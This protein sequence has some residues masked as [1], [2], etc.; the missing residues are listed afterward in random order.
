MGLPGQPHT[1]GKRTQHQRGRFGRSGRGGGEMRL[2]PLQYI[3]VA[4]RK[5]GDLPV[6]LPPFALWGLLCL[7]HTDQQWQG[8]KQHS[9]FVHAPVSFPANTR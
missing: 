6:G 4:A 8:G 2:L 1:V 7:C 3:G 5:L 9:W